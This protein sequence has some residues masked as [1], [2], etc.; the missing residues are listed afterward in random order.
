M[1]HYVG[2]TGLALALLVAACLAIEGCSDKKEVPP[3]LVGIYTCTTA[4]N[5]YYYTLSNH[6]DR[7]SRRGLFDAGLYLELRVDGTFTAGLKPGLCELSPGIGPAWCFASGRWWCR[8]GRIFILFDYSEKDAVI[9]GTAFTR[10]IKL[11]SEAAAE[12]ERSLRHQQAMCIESGLGHCLTNEDIEDRVARRDREE[13]SIGR[14]AAMTTVG[15]ERM[16]SFEDGSQWK[17]TEVSPS[18]LPW[19]K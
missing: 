5:P 3:S 14:S 2:R 17:K 6:G 4:S 12:Y 18:V 11:L 8:S 9:S 13:Q 10:P 15:G 1:Q 7:E 19:R 16:L